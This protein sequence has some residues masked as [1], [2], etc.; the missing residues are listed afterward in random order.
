M[1]EQ[2]YVILDTGVIVSRPDS[3]SRYAER[4]WPQLRHGPHRVPVTIDGDR[5]RHESGWTWP[6]WATGQWS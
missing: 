2:T 3:D 1:A 5:Y 4:V 6:A